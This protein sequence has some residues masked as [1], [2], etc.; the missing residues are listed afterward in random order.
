MDLSVEI[1]LSGRREVLLPPS[2]SLAARELVIAALTSRESL[3]QTVTVLGT[4]CDDTAAMARALT[5][6]NDYTHVIECTQN[7]EYQAISSPSKIEGAGG[8]MKIFDDLGGTSPKSKQVLRR[9]RI[10]QVFR[11]SS[12]QISLESLSY[13][14]SI[15]LYLRGGADTQQLNHYYNSNNYINVE[16]A[17]TA[18]RFLTAFMACQRG[19]CVTLDGNQRMR[20]RPI[21]PLVDALRHMGAT[22]DYIDRKGFPPLK[23][24]GRKLHGGALALRG[25]VS[26]QFTSALLMVAPVAGG[27]TLTLEGDIV[28][29]PYIDMTLAL[30]RHHG[31]EA[32]WHDGAIVVPAGCYTAAAPHIEGDWSAASY[33]LG[34]KALAPQ[35]C[36]TLS[37]LSEHSLQGDH[38]IATMMEPLGVRVRYYNNKCVTLEHDAV[39]LPSRYCR[40]MAATPDLVPTLAVT[41]C[42]LRV[43]FAL[44]GVATLRLKESDRLEALRQELGQLGYCVEAGDNALRYDGNH[45]PPASP[46]VLDPHGDHRLAMALSL[47]AT[48]HHGIVINNAQVVTKSYPTWWQQLLQ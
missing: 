13:S 9:Y 36:I 4:C 29:R 42:L 20:H 5:S 40:D 26:S 39:Q 44:T 11:N 6:H 30:M 10:A 35:L 24:E 14:P 31:I 16:G 15:P 41:L 17:G 28:S 45:T 12:K 22:I 48:R 34:L 21:A 2:K 7:D 1:P 23:I 37:P 38:A 3:S 47:A 27:I 33:W 43:P 32:R 25:D 46:P 19:R 18:M 8:S